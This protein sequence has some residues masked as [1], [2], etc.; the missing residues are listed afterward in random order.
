[1][2]KL[3]LLLLSWIVAVPAP[4]PLPIRG[5]PAAA[6]PAQ[7]AL[8]EKARAIPDAQRLRSYMEATTRE[9]HIA[10]SPQ[11]KAVAEYLLRLLREWGLDA[12]IE[13]FEALLPWPTERALE[14]VA[15]VKYR[16]SL[17]EPVLETDR[18]SR[19]KNHIPTYNAYSASGRVTAPLIYVNY[20]IPEDYLELKNRGIDVRGKIVIARY[21][22]SWRGTKAKVA[23]ENGAAGC[24][25]YSDPREDG[26]FQGDAYP[27]GP[28]RPSQ[29]VQRGSVLDM[30]LYPGDPLSPG[31]ALES[32]SRRLDRKEATSIMRIPV[33]PIS[34]S[35]A[36]HLMEH[37]GGPVVPEGWR[38]ALPLTY[39]FGP[40]PAS[41]HLRVDFDWTVKP[42]YNVIATIPGSVSPDEWIIYGNHHDAWN[43][44]AHDPISGA[45]AV[46]ETG[47][48]LAQ[49]GREGW[50]PKRTIKLALW[51]GE[52][53]GLHGS[54]E[55]VEKHGTELARKAVVYF[56]SDTN[57]KGVLSAGGTPALQTFFTQVL[58]DVNQPGTD[59]SVLAKRPM[60]EGK[61]TPFRLAPVGAGSDY[62]AF[63]HHAGIPS[64]NAGFSSGDS[65]G[66]YHSVYDSFDWY[67]KF[68][69]ADFSH[70][71][72]LTQVMATAILRLSEAP[73]LPFE[74]G[75][76]AQAIEEWMKDLPKVDVAELTQALQEL[77]S[78]AE[79]YERAFEAAQTA[80]ASA[81]TALNRTE[82]ALLID[83]G[84]PGRPW[85]KHALMAPGLYTGYSAKTLP[86][87]R[88]SK[89]P[90]SGVKITAD[91]IRGYAA[92]VEAAARA[93]TP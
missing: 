50:R 38:G 42:I 18:A 76:A 16:A 75:S 33:L 23:Q 24:L 64:I 81:N 26:F 62:V 1:M 89:D 67:A 84:L 9:P 15:P 34:W 49:L 32:G 13:Q 83:S 71:R 53:F 51:D 87:I 48:T 6:L 88:D 82:R 46:L 2:K 4:A 29:G 93:L 73:V 59:G 20:G 72:A 11:S 37:L 25:I 10:G 3:A 47:R 7:R 35:D 12:R 56:N 22:K 90:Q 86:A 17:H 28:F 19:N 45:I 43:N 57:N 8:E 55:W 85:Y 36:Q 21:G 30:P 31:W 66:I 61:P 60:A 63:I 39:H 54:T 74:F 92:S 70:A 40:G 77:R 79:K 69:D 68:G 14:L 78:A 41:V 5:F 65:G 44:G 52:E 91:A 80:P 27:Q 58:R